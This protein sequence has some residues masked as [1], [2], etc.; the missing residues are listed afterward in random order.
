MMLFVCIA[1][2]WKLLTLYSLVLLQSI[3]FLF[4]FVYLFKETHDFCFISLGSHLEPMQRSYQNYLF[5]C[6]VLKTTQ[7]KSKARPPRCTRALSSEV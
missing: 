3:T 6:H 4:L 7:A 1:K 2:Y 5:C